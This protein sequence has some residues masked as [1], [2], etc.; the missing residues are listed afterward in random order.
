MTKR[1]KKEKKKKMEEKKKKKKK[2]KKNGG[3]K[4]K[5]KKNMEQFF[6]AIVKGKSALVE[7]ILVKYSHQNEMILHSYTAQGKV[8]LI[9]FFIYLFIHLLNF[10]LLRIKPFLIKKDTFVISD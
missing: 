3:K 6:Q 5:K 2:K 7:Q 8:K 9:F 10:I 1:R 4:K